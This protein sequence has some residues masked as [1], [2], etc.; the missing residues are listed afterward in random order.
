MHHDPRP[1]AP[2]SPMSPK[3]WREQSTEFIFRCACTDSATLHCILCTKLVP[4][5]N[6]TEDGERRHPE[7]SGR[8]AKDTLHSKREIERIYSYTHELWYLGNLR[9]TNQ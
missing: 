9:E 6:K 8:P 4:G 3:C 7:I 2:H 1:R 5:P